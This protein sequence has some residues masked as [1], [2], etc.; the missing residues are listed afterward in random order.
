VGLRIVSRE[1]R[2]VALRLRLILHNATNG[3]P[4]ALEHWAS[5]NAGTNVILNGNS[6]TILPADEITL[7]NE[8]PQCVGIARFLAF[9]DPDWLDHSD[10]LLEIEDTIRDKMTR[11]PLSVTNRSMAARNVLCK[12]SDRHG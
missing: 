11:H 8:S 12:Q 3:E 9:G 10:A 7:T 5:E 4:H 6:W 1:T 2:P